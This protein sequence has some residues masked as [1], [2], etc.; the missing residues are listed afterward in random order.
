[1]DFLNGLMNQCIA[2][3]NRDGRY[4]IKEQ[5]KGDPSQGFL[6]VMHH[7]FEI[8]R[9]TV[10]QESDYYLN[11]S[12]SVCSAVCGINHLVH[13]MEAWDRAPGGFSGIF[14][15]FFGSARNKLPKESV[16][17]F[18]MDTDFGDLVLHYCQI[19]KT[20]WEVFNDGDLEIFEPA[21]QPLETVSGEFDVFWGSFRMDEELKSKFDIFLKNNGKDAKDAELRLGYVCVAKWE[22]EHGFEEKEIKKKITERMYISEIS[23]HENDLVVAKR[24][25][26]KSREF[27]HDLE[28]D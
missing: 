12:P 21:I 14:T 22:N 25:F 2:V 3:I 26:P 18:S 23:F 7:H 27:Y 13:E 11:S 19:G 5:A 6:N 1:M 24:S 20:W 16:K 4:S 28:L 10:W 17:D 8:L 15:E 9:G